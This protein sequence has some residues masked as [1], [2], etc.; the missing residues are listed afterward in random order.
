MRDGLRDGRFGRDKGLN[1]CHDAIAVVV[2]VTTAVASGAAV[3]VLVIARL[4]WHDRVARAVILG[5]RGALLNGD[6]GQ[7]SDSRE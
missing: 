7:G 4:Q 2:A 1:H 3:W 6:L 5:G